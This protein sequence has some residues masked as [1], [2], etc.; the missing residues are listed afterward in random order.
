MN[1]QIYFILIAATCSLFIPLANASDPS[2]VPEGAQVEVIQSKITEEAQRQ[3]ESREELPVIEVVDELPVK[4]DE[5]STPFFVKKIVMEGDGVALGKDLE[6]LT[7]SYEERAIT[8]K[9]LKRLMN[10]IE[11]IYRAKGFFGVIYAP[12]QRIEEGVVTLRA[13][14][15]E[16][17]ELEISETNYF[18]KSRIQ[19]LWKIPSGKDLRYDELRNN[20]LELN[21]N[22]DRKIRA[23]LRAG[24]KPE[25]TN[26]VL[27]VEENFPIHLGYSFDNQGVKLTGKGE[28]VLP[29]AIITS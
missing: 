5:Q 10:D 15:S 6:I 27:N 24:K 11:K 13:V 4:D 9:E 22:P 16:M 23:G 26:V 18:R 14:T 8:F 21:Q 2:D 3:L 17:G 20:L 1:R 19:S 25:T 29:F 28:M 12:P 7:K